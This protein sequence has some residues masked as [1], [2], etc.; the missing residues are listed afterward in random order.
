MPT[1][2]QAQATHFWLLVNGNPVG[3]FDSDTIKAKLS[4]GEITEDSMACPLGSHAWM[5][6]KQL[7]ASG[8]TDAIKAG[9]ALAVVHQA[10]P[11]A[12][13][14]AAPDAIVIIK[15]HGRSALV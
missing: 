13:H 3:P 6:L 7:L 14:Q 10:S 15:K 9:A 5:S 1:S 2:S 4:A 11:P 12:S 8:H